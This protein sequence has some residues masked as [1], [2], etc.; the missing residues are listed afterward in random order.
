MK[1]ILFSL[2]FLS[3]NNFSLAQITG[4]VIGVGGGA[5]PNVNII[6]EGTKQGTVTDQNGDFRIQVASFP[7]FL[8]FSSVGYER[9]RIEFGQ[10][11]KG[12]I[13]VLGTS[14]MEGEAVFVEGGRIVSPS[15]ERSTIPITSLLSKD[16]TLKQNTTA[17]DLLRSESGVY[18]QQT[19]PGQGSVYVRGRAGRDVL[20]LFH[21]LRMNPSFVRSGQNQ[22]FGVIDPFSVE[23]MDVFR[24][25]ISTFYGSDALTGGIN[26][27]PELSRLTESSDWKYSFRSQV[28]V[29]GSGEKSLHA[30]FGKNGSV[31][32]WKTSGTLR[33]FEYYQMS[34]NNQDRLWFPYSSRLEDGD[35]SFQAINSSMSWQLSER[36]R[37][38]ALFYHGVIP[39]APRWD[40]MIIGYS[41]SDSPAR[42]YDSN[43]Y[44]LAFT[45]AQ[46]EWS[47]SAPMPWLNTVKAHIGYHRLK[48]FRRS[49]S[50]VRSPSWTDPTIVGIPE[51]KSLHDN[52][53][54]DQLHLS[55]DLRSLIK[56][57]ILLR[58][59]TDLSYD[60]T[61]SKQYLLNEVNASREEYLPRYPD[62]SN[63]LQSGIF[64]HLSHYGLG[65]I[66]VEG[67]IRFSSV[68]ADLPMEGLDS[69][70]G[71]EPYRKWF[72]QLTATT[73][74]S[75][76]IGEQLFLLANLG[77]GFRAPN[78][79]DLS[80]LGIRRS[81]V[82][83]VANPDLKPEQSINVDVGLRYRSGK[84][85]TEWS[86]FMINYLNKI[87]NQFTG[88]FVDSR[89]RRVETQD[90]PLPG[91]GLFYES[92]SANAD[93]KYLNGIEAQIRYSLIRGFDAGFVANLISGRV[94]GS[95]GIRDYIDRLP[96]TNG[97]VFTEIKAFENRLS[98]RPQARFALQKTKLAVEERSD[99]RINPNGTDGFINLQLI[100][101]F[102]INK[103]FEIRLFGDNLSD[104]VYREHGSS[105]N[106]MARNVTV[107]LNYSF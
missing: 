2:L 107:S 75:Y 103:E 13:V 47:H 72:S 5:I 54:S 51:Q 48:D 97:Q 49:V 24:G 89:G 99:N 14:T 22:Y 21:G 79:A 61:H 71:F 74:A 9:R 39:K 91:N 34:Q 88:F 3:L 96:P 57:D 77:S 100:S 87:S 95:D 16:L 58:W 62:G 20:Y 40:R 11:D 15:D 30:G 29:G 104:Q 92:I 27:Q 69:D 52:N 45:A 41:E 63:Y 81:N 80:E 12:I 78:I 36:N 66:R 28:N 37:I 8:I 26:I 84:F 6:I 33:Y 55:I 56:K 38:Q 93:S 85:E 102:Q 105:L 18:V 60:L 7:A 35:F 82:Y 73:G 83:Q 101:S 59:G 31:F 65:R 53:I 32:S 68:Y 1:A 94:R 70:R 50:F 42:Y 23:R 98:L 10:A 44:P 43:T 19:T 106:G 17:A 86:I 64:A 90:T 4:K 46:V 76:K 67:G 25:P